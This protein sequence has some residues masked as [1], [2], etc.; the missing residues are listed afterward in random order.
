MFYLLVGLLVLE[1][2]ALVVKLVWRRRARPSPRRSRS[3]RRPADA[4]VRAV[5]MPRS[6][7]PPAGVAGSF[8]A[9]RSR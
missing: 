2:P 5:V 4:P 6:R 3:R 8:S 9:A 1:I 7:R